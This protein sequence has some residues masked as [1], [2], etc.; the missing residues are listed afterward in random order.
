[1]ENSQ[2]IGH[3]REDLNDEAST[4]RTLARDLPPLFYRPSSEGSGRVLRYRSGLSLHGPFSQPLIKYSSNHESSGSAEV[5]SPLESRNND[6]SLLERSNVSGVASSSE[7]SSHG[8]TVGYRVQ[9]HTAQASNSCEGENFADLDGEADLA[10]TPQS[11]AQCA[12]FTIGIQDD[13][14]TQV[15]VSAGNDPVLPIDSSPPPSYETVCQKKIVRDST[16]SSHSTVDSL[17]PPTY[18]DAVGRGRYLED[19][20]PNYHALFAQSV[21]RMM[22]LTSEIVGQANDNEERSCCSQIITYMFL[23]GIIIFI[24]AMAVPLPFAMIIIGVTHLH[25]CPAQPRIPVF[26]TSL[27]VF[28]LLE[29]LGRLSMYIYSKLRS[30]SHHTHREDARYRSKDPFVYFIVV[31]FVVGSMWVYQNYPSCHDINSQDIDFSRARDFH[32]TEVAVSKTVRT[33]THVYYKKKNAVKFKTTL[34]PTAASIGTSKSQLQDAIRASKQ[35]PVAWRTTANII[36]TTSRQDWTSRPTLGM[37][38]ERQ[39]AACC[40]RVVYFFTFGI[41]TFYYSLIGTLF[42]LQVCSSFASMVCKCRRQT[43]RT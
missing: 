18:R 39:E 19:A 34:K 13:A 42:L 30:H 10:S 11:S 5:S 33:T 2:Q 41:V 8:I 25:S 27:G 17:Q 32:N 23:S 36:A 16:A 4:D 38:E 14:Q 20:P 24:A 37:Q 28:Q 31:W 3:N 26:L 1:M 29:C 15:N 7:Q 43:S 22:D 12:C 40:G 21:F 35:Q 6:D 9:T